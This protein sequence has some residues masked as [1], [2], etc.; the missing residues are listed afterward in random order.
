MKNV[1]LTI[2]TALDGYSIASASGEITSF[3]PMAENGEYY[4]TGKD[5]GTEPLS[6]G[7]IACRLEDKFELMFVEKDK[8]DFRIR[9]KQKQFEEEVKNEE[10]GKEN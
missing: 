4:I 10:S 2:A 9:L 1:L 7:Q 6:I 5:G 3:S 8:G